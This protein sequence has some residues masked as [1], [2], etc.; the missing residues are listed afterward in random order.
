M[1]VKK[2][3]NQPNQPSSGTTRPATEDLTKSI[4]SGSIDFGQTRSKD[5][6]V[7]NTLPPPPKKENK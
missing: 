2:S 7:V 4:G 6:V 1:T 5:T 3:N